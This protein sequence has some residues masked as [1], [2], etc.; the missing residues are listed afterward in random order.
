MRGKTSFVVHDPK[1]S[2]F[3][4]GPLKPL[5]VERHIGR[6]PLIAAGNGT[7]DIQLLTYTNDRHGTSLCVVINHDDASR[8]FDYRADEMLRVAR[9]HGWLIVSVKR[10]WKFVFPN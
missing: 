2:S 10:D 6:R 9:E 8:E 1:A 5:N 3:E 4:N 7:S